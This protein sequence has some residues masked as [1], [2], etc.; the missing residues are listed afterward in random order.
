MRFFH[1]T[2]TVFAEQF[3][4][5]MA[6][7]ADA[8][9][10]AKTAG[11]AGFYLATEHSD[12]EYFAVWLGEGTLD[13]VIVVDIEEGALTSL[14]EAG[15]TLAPFVNNGRPPFFEGDELFV[16]A[17]AFGLYNELVAEG[18]IRVSA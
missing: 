6:L 11:K 12:A 3:R 18:R 5:G 2:K 14:R 17:S 16:P 4:A 1:G 15:A 13:D 10:A 8:A 7:S 9:A